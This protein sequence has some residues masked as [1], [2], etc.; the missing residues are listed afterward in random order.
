MIE[1]ASGTNDTTREFMALGAPTLIV[2]G[3]ALT[4]LRQWDA[5]LVVL[6]RRSPRLGRRHD[7]GD[8]VRELADAIKGLP[9]TR[10][11]T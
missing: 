1:S 4:L 8:Q 6:R 11:F 5:E 3:P 9:G 10:A 2:A 7:T